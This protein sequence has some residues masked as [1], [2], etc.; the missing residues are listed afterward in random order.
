VEDDDQVRAV[1]RG[2]LKRNGYQVV[3][4]AHAPGALEAYQRHDGP[5]DLLLTDVVMPLMNGPAVARQLAAANPRIKVLYM[6]GYTDDSV[7]RHGVETSATPFVQKPFTPEVLLRRVR[8]V[9]DGGD[10]HR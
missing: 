9:L 1:A 10:E 2:I 8:Q 5:I 6:S 4:V 7:L 3:E